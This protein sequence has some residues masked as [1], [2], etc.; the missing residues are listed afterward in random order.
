M[1]GCGCFTTDLGGNPPDGEP[2]NP[3]EM[4]AAG[5]T[6]AAASPDL[7][8]STQIHGDIS[9]LLH[10]LCAATHV[11]LAH[12]HGGASARSGRRQRPAVR[13]ALQGPSVQHQGQLHR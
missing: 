9:H 4:R 13:S 5:N 3:L 12:I 10:Q 11:E 2:I 7:P 1:T 8:S 6:S